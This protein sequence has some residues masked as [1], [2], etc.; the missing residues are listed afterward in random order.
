MSIH[1]MARYH[2][3]Q[4]GIVDGGE[5]GLHSR[6]HVTPK[7]RNHISPYLVEQ[8]KSTDYQTGVGSILAERQ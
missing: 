6:K 1:I 8:Y 3:D 2:G 4:G 7:T 5:K